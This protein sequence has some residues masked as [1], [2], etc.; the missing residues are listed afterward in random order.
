MTLPIY[1]LEMAIQ[2]NYFFSVFLWLK[3]LCTNLFTRG[4]AGFDKNI[5]SVLT[6]PP[7]M[8]LKVHSNSYFLN[9]SDSKPVNVK[10]IINCCKDNLIYGISNSSDP[11]KCRIFTDVE[12]RQCRT[13]EHL[14][15]CSQQWEGCTHTG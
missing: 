11:F 2:T 15:V 3:W 7:P 5:S 9:F 6:S 12:L 4:R 8:I 13:F 10:Y 1:L 14:R